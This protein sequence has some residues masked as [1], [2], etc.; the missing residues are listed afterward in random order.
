MSTHEAQIWVRPSEPH[1]LKIETAG[2]KR[3]QAVVIEMEW[4]LG[5]LLNFILR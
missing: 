3:H 4:M 1:G 2:S 5:K